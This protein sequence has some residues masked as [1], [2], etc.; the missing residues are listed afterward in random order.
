M[1]RKNKTDKLGVCSLCAVALGAFLLIPL[2]AQAQ[3]RGQI[4][5]TQTPIP[6]GVSSKKL[7]RFLKKNRTKT[8]KPAPGSKSYK[9]YVAARLRR[10]PSNADMKRNNGQLHL[11]FYV[12]KKRKWSYHNVMHINYSQGAVLQFQLQIPDG[13]GIEPGKKYQLRLTILNSR[14]KEVVLA[15]TTFSVK[16][17]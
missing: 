5:L 2:K 14:N 15:K 1:K 12:R 13:F 11:A 16:A 4:I 9:C 10:K 8:L 7:R 3:S 6:K 17:K